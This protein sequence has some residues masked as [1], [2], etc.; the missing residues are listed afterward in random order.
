MQ[1]QS[2]DTLNKSFNILRNIN[3]KVSNGFVFEL[4]FILYYNT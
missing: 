1:I 4:S 2:L 3:R